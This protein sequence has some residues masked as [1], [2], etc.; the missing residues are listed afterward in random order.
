MKTHAIASFHRAPERLNCAQAVLFGYQ[1][2]THDRTIPVVDFK[3]FGGGRA[4]GGECGALHAACLL[5]PK[6]A[7]EIRRAF[8]GCA[9]ATR[10]K[11]LNGFACLKCVELAAHLLNEHT[12]SKTILETPPVQ[13]PQAGA[14]SA[15]S[16][17]PRLPNIPDDP[18]AILP[19][20]RDAGIGLNGRTVEYLSDCK[21]EPSWLRAQ[22]RAA[23]HSFTAAERILQW[24][25]PSLAE[26]PLDGLRYYSAPAAVREPS[27]R[28]GTA[29]VLDALG[30]ARDEAAFLG[31]SQAQIDGEVVYGSLAETW[32]RAGVVF[33][34]STRGLIEHG[35]LFR[36]H[37]G[38]VVGR[39]ENLF[40]RLN[41]AVFS[42]GSFIHV[43]PG[44]QL[45]APLKCFMHLQGGGSTQ[46]GRT[47]I[48]VGEGAEVT[49]F[50]SC[51]SAARPG[52]ALHCAVGE[53]VLGRD[54]KLNYVALQNW[55]PNVFNLAVLRA[56]LAAGASIRW[57]DCNVGGR[58]TMKYPC[59]LLEGEGASAEAMS[60]SVARTGQ[61]HDSGAKM[62]HL[63]SNTSSTITAK[64]VSIGEGR[65]GYRGWVRMPASV[66]RCHNHTECDALLVDRASRTDTYPAIQVRGYDNTAQHEA[67]VS[68]LDEEQ[69][70]YMRQRGLSEDVA[71]GLSIN[72]F[73]SD[74][75]QRF[76]LQYSLEIKKLI[77]LEM[78]GS[79]G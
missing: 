28:A 58:L 21:A 61:H 17:M 13:S 79:V 72:G 75:V 64:S 39:D 32:A 50:E 42:G 14:D 25:P 63:A 2:I 70:F 23:L 12:L 76:P 67:S 33:V 46:F 44:V 45:T 47:L 34:D 51:T 66:H 20:E 56:R 78:S 65:S 24:A 9:G 53:F 5:A 26:I 60:I 62:F 36:P 37:F 59:A 48:V 77:E 27:G 57:I 73:V 68:R 49:F 41:A 40:T 11:E 35:S 69:I 55:K 29:R 31:G 3:P 43:P 30:V 6:A 71:R 18:P 8:R 22:R 19:A 10:C 16:D 38:T 52:P 74:L 4:P 1:S 15:S 7:T 54:A